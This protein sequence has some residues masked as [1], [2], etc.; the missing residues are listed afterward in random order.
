MSTMLAFSESVEETLK[1]RAL[2]KMELTEFKNDY[3]ILLY[4]GRMN[5]RVRQMQWHIVHRL[6]IAV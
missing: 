6:L 3:K 4:G 1:Y 2:L 5:L